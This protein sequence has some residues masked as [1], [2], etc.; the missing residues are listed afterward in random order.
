[1]KPCLP[2]SISRYRPQCTSASLTGEEEAPRQRENCT[3]R[4]LTASRRGLFLLPSCICWIFFFLSLSLSFTNWLDKTTPSR[5]AEGIWL[6][7]RYPQLSE[8][9]PREQGQGRR[10]IEKAGGECAS[11]ATWGSFS[12]QSPGT[13]L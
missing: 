9:L 6:S 8:H 11:S 13:E 7:Q 10:C 3:V 5:L 4:T 2:P 1:M 12:L